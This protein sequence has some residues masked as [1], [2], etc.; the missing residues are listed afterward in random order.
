MIYQLYGKEE[1]VMIDVYFFL[2]TPGEAV[3]AF[4]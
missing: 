4:L 1:I 3:G 2:K